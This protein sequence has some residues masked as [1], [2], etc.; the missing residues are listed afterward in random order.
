MSFRFYSG[1]WRRIAGIFLTASSDK[2]D[3]L[4]LV[5]RFNSSSGLSGPL[6]S[7]RHFFFPLLIRKHYA[8]T[9][10]RPVSIDAENKQNAD[11]HGVFGSH[12][13]IV[14]WCG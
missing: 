4:V 10:L 5:E 8:E 13:L 3:I 14:I 2:I 7:M 12:F 1:A 11:L 6:G 9:S